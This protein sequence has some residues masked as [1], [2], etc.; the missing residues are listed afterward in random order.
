MTM[1]TCEH[2]IV[3]T[4]RARCK[5]P[6]LAQLSLL[7][8]SRPAAVILREKD[9][10]LDAYYDLAMQV[11][12]LCAF[13]HV[14]CILHEHLSAARALNHSRVHLSLHSLEQA[15]N[16]RKYFAEI[17]ASV[18]SVEEAQRAYCLGAAYVIAGHIFPT[19]CKEG[20]PPRGL[21]FLKQLRR[22]VPIPVYAIGGI[23][24]ENQHLVLQSGADKVCIM[25]GAMTADHLD[26]YAMRTEPVSPA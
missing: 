26:A 14:P 1:C 20:L 3:V 6:L 10:S 13:Y 8:P 22:A 17:G 4:N 19:D 23:L 21:E 16:Q 12:T 24:P 7:L 15:R 2:L 11:Q 9:L 5:R 18:H 25:S